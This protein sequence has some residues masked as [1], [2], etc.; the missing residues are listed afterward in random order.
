M[1]KIYDGREHFFQW[2]VDRKLIID[3]PEIVEVHFTNR[4]TD[5]ALACAT[6]VEDGKTLVNVPNILLQTDWRIQAYAYDGKHTKHSAC[7]VVNTRSKPTD[8]IY[9]ETELLNY[10]ELAEDFYDALGDINSALGLL[11]EY[12]ENVKVN[13]VPEEVEEPEG[14]EEQ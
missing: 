7:Y 12:A 4:T 11:H 2:D 8:Y 3:D 6:Y 9:T 10:K 14:V 13:G 1:F 5:Y